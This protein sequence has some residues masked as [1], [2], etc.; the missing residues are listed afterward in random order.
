MM[1]PE[2]IIHPFRQLPGVFTF[3]STRKGG[4]SP[5]PYD[6]LNLAFHTGDQPA[7]V[8]NNRQRLQQALP[9]GLHLQFMQQVHACNITLIESPITPPVC[10]ALISQSVGVCLCVL[11]A[12]CLPI[13]FYASKKKVIGAVHAGWRGLASRLIPKVIGSMQKNFGVQASELH[14]GIGPHISRYAYEVGIEVIEALKK[15]VHP[16]YR[17][18]VGI[19]NLENGRYY[20]DLL[21]VAYAQLAEFGISAKQVDTFVACTWQKNELFYSA[22]REGQQSGRFATGIALMQ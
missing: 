17:Q 15:A 12:D 6:S 7:H 14:V 3:V 5:K 21:A 8:L 16:I 13:W 19:P 9:A 1:L 4:V 18:K 11:S 22:R 2:C 10:D 20:A